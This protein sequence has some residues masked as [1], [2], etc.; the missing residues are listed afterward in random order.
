MKMKPCQHPNRQCCLQCNLV[1]HLIIFISHR[2]YLHLYR[3]QANLPLPHK[4]FLLLLK[5]AI[6]IFKNKCLQ[7]RHLLQL[8]RM[9]LILTLL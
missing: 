7:L 3:V 4:W 9:R 1:F 5:Q 2:K 6:I 8:N